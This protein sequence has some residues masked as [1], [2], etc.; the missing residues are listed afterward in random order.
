MS[1]VVESLDKGFVVDLALS[2]EPQAH[3]R[4]LLEPHREIWF[5]SRECEFPKIGGSNMLQ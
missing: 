2:P 5:R 4:A 1:C 3:L